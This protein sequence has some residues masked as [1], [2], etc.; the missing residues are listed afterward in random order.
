MGRTSDMRTSPDI[1]GNEDM[2]GIIDSGYKRK[3]FVLRCN[4][5]TNNPERFRVWSFKAIAGLGRLHDTIEDRAIPVN[6]QRRKRSTKIVLLRDRDQ[7]Q[8]TRLKRQIHRWA[9]DNGEA[10]QSHR[11]TIP[12]VLNDREGQLW[13]PMF[14]VADLAGVHWSARA[15]AVSK[16]L[17]GSEVDDENFSIILLLGLRAILTDPDH[18][19]QDFF[20]SAGLILGLNRDDEA[21]WAN[22]SKGDVKGL[23]VEKL[24]STL[25][26]YGLK[27]KQST[28]RVDRSRGYERS[29]LEAVFEQYL[30]NRG[31]SPENDTQPVHTTCQSATRAVSHVNGLKK[32]PVHEGGCAQDEKTTCARVDPLPERVPEQRAQDD[33]VFTPR[34]IPFPDFHENGTQNTHDDVAICKDDDSADS[35]KKRLEGSEREMG[36]GNSKRMEDQVS[37]SGLTVAQTKMV[38]DWLKDWKHTLDTERRLAEVEAQK[39]K[40]RRYLEQEFFTRHPVTRHPKTWENDRQYDIEG[41]KR[42]IG[43]LQVER[44]QKN[45]GGF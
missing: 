35:L 44:D 38:R 14:C 18:A 10:I 12:V 17:S 1:K 26:P 6:L 24:A 5:V 31:V 2:R 33:T 45:G 42:L 23:T 16:T 13:T 36:I 28:E 15:R 3:G 34:P 11:P 4:P 39:E 21:P 27:S 8:I 25:K 32:Q 22:W 41:A 40:T 37:V 20:S 9:L 19:H 30:E 29:A 43:R 7:D